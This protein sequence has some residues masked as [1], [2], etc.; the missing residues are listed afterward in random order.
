[1]TFNQFNWREFI[2]RGGG[3]P[4]ILFLIASSAPQAMAQPSDVEQSAIR[5]ALTRPCASGVRSLFP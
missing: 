3:L 2:A 1:M 5:A 4:A